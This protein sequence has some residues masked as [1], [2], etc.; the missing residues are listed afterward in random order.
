VPDTHASEIRRLTARLRID[1][2]PR[3]IHG[4]GNGPID[5]FIDALA[6]DCGIAI[7]IRNY[8]EHALGTGADASAV[9]YVEAV[10]PAGATIW[11]VGIDP[12]IVLASLRAVLGAANQAWP[13]PR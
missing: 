4:R 3:E 12:N 8:S 11:G 13:R 10:G 9:A 7:Q 5:A 6:K 2:E 1:A